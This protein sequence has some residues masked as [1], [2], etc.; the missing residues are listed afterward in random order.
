MREE[1]YDLRKEIE[2]LKMEKAL[3]EKQLGILPF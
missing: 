1:N 2:K 3:L